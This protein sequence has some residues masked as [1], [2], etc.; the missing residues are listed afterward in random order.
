MN[1]IR[2]VMA[3]IPELD[4]FRERLESPDFP[5]AV[6]V[7]EARWGLAEARQKAQAELNLEA[8]E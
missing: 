8:G 3:A 5:T 7:A 4:R 2:E 1:S 6:E